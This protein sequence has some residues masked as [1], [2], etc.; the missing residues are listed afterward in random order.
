MS[1]QADSSM[2]GIPTTFIQSLNVIGLRRFAVS[3]RIVKIAFAATLCSAGAYGMLS[4]STYIS[5]SNAVISA[6]I[7]DVRTPIDGVVSGLPLAVGSVVR[8]GQFLGNVENPR[9]DRQHLDNLLTLESSSKSTVNALSAERATLEEQQRALLARA[10]IDSA[11]VGARLEEQATAAAR[12]LSGLRLAVVEATIEFRRGE[13]LHDAGI[14]SDAAFDRV[15][16]VQLIAVEA[17]AAQQSTLASLRSQATDA[18]HGI[19]AEPGDASDVSYSRQRADEIAIKLAE[20][21]GALTIARRQADEAQLNVE[22]ETVRDG[23]M[24]Q[25]VVDAPMDGVLWKINAT[26]GEG[27]SSGS[28]ILSMVNCSQQ[29]VLAQVPQDRVPDVAIHREARI[30]LAGETEEREGRVM[31]VSG[32]A[33]KRP[34]AKLAA[35]P[36]EESSQQMATVLIL[37]N[38]SWRGTSAGYADRDARGE[39]VSCFVG[40]TARVLIPTYSTNLAMRWMYEYF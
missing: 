26:N 24:R 36:I 8:A 7:V 6:D 17:V 20:N 5:S 14:I 11:A 32:D 1:I 30:R 22:A 16:S 29:F 19:L 15:R 13:Q 3:R 4:D 33:L 27:L 2:Q 35:L 39:S 21:A 28:S 23:L 31:S 18:A 40:R 9:S 34:D 12:T 37:L 25:S 38:T 10:D